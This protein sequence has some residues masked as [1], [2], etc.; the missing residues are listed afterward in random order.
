MISQRLMCV[1]ILVKKP[2][3]ENVVR[4]ADVAVDATEITHSTSLLRQATTTQPRKIGERTALPSAAT[5]MRIGG[6]GLA[7]VAAIAK[8]KL[9][10]NKRHQKIT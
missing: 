1:I 9:A 8:R 2:N 10:A 6:D 3:A 5:M 7:R 4:E